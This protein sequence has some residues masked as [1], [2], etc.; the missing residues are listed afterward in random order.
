MNLV[1][2]GLTISSS[3]G[4]GHATLWRSLCRGLHARGHDVTFFER[5]VPYYEQARDLLD[6]DGCTLRLYSNWEEIARDA[7]EALNA[8]DVGLVTS[9]CPDGAIAAATVLDSRARV[10]VFYDLDTPI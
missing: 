1:V 6:P 10:K 2:F 9:Y 8:S 3:W 7:R 4:N 5:D